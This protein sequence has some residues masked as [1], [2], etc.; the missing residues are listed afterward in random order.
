[1]SEK[2][3][4]AYYRVSTER[5]GRS[6]LGLDAQREAVAAFLRPAPALLLSEFTEAESG[7]GANALAR[8]PQLRAALDAAK[9]AGATLLIAKLDRLARNVAFIAQL[10]DGGVDFVAV[11][12]PTANRLTLHILAAVAEHER[13]MI[14]ERTRSA[15]AAAKARGRA[16]GANGAILALKNKGEAEQRLAPFGPQLRELQSQRMP[17]RQI[18]A[19]LNRLG[20]PSPGGG[21]WHTTT[22][23]R[24]LTRLAAR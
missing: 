8:R 19:E 20:L 16:L 23:H 24:A 9:R 7:K 18:A 5:Q 1:M 3:F 10:M 4:V 2:K 14:S 21:H 11:D 22:V 13:E 15:L 17:I 12:N 6:G